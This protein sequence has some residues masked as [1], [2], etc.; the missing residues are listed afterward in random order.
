M[1]K[2]KYLLTELSPHQIG[3][4]WK[5][6]LYETTVGWQVRVTRVPAITDMLS[7]VISRLH[8]CKTL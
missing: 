4:N 7:Q 3:P 2:K 5:I 1:T 8:V 6:L